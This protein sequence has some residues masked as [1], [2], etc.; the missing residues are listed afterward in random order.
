M[1]WRHRQEPTL[2]E[3]REGRLVAVDPAFLFGAIDRMLGG[4]GETD[5]AS[6]EMTA[7]E[8]ALT[9]K[10]LEPILHG[11]RWLGIDWDEGPDV[12]GPH[13]PYFQAQRLEEIGLV[14]RKVLST[15]PIA[16]AYQITDFGRTALDV[17]DQRVGLE[18]SLPRFVDRELAGFPISDLEFRRGAWIERI[19][20]A[21]SPSS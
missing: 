3:R 7:T 9:E 12:E 14:E 2:Y 18:G 1:G 21:T 16:V 4:T 10:L 11:F 8:L 19:V 20:L 5:P 15:R 13:A 6:R 17:L